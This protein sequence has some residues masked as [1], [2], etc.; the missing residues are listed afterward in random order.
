MSA[1]VSMSKKAFVKEHVSLVKTLKSGNKKKLA[2]E[3][4]EQA[5][6]LKKVNKNGKKS[7]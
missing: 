3:A 7:K 1:K 6:E 5:A 4:K 2:K